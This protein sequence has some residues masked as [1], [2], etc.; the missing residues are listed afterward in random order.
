MKYDNVL[1]ELKR[2]AI[3][4]AIHHEHITRC[5]YEDLLRTR[6]VALITAAETV[7][8]IARWPC[9]GRHMYEAECAPC[10]C[11]RAMKGLEL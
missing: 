11:R 2:I 10:L 1:E 7:E 4:C 9:D 6:S 8:R 3:S 5:A